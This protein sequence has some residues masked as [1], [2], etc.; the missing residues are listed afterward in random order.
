MRQGFAAQMLI[1]LEIGK[2]TMPL[3]DHMALADGY[4]LHGNA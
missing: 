3:I 1:Q 2:M 4:Q